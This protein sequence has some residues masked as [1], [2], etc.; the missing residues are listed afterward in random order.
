[1]EIIRNYELLNAINNSSSVK[2]N[3]IDEWK[4]IYND[5][6]IMRQIISYISS[7][8]DRINLELTC[9]YLKYLSSKA[10]YISFFDDNTA[11]DLNFS[12]IDPVMSLMIAGNEITVPALVSSDRYT[13]DCLLESQ[14]EPSV[15]ILDKVVERCARQ[16]QQ[17]KLGGLTDCER[18]LGYLPEH[19]VT[20]CFVHIQMKGSYLGD[21]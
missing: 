15:H 6:Y 8:K 9:S 21:A 16:V 19:Q 5:E 2:E 12:R 4:M 13:T 20:A 17:L 18:R 1:M 14:P 3:D 11:L 10:S 7:F